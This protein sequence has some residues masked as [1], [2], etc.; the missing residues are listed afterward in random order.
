MSQR[1]LVIAR[2]RALAGEQVEQGLALLQVREPLGRGLVQRWGKGPPELA[3]QPRVR[4]VGLAAPQLALGE[5]ARLQGVDH[6]HR[7]LRLAQGRQ[8]TQAVGAGGLQ[9]AGR[10][11]GQGRQQLGIAGRGLVQALHAAGQVGIYVVLANI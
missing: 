10:L 5:A 7:P 9:Y 11:G 6:A 1:V 4:P 2:G 8:Q 3:Q